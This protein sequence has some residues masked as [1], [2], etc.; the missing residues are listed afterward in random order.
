MLGWCL[1]L[2]LSWC[3]FVRVCGFGNSLG[4]DEGLEVGDLRGEGCLGKVLLE[5]VCEAV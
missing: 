2:G 3:R 1:Q 4:G 5:S